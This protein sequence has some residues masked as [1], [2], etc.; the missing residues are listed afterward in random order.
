[1]PKKITI[2]LPENTDMNHITHPMQHNSLTTQPGQRKN[3]NRGLPRYEFFQALVQEKR[4]D[5]LKASV[6]N[7]KKW[8]DYLSALGQLKQ[9]KLYN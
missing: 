2:Q 9:L 3:R 6:G 7:S 8:L 5:F 1:M 4:S